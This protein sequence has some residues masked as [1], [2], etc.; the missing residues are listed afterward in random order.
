MYAYKSVFS[1]ILFFQHMND[2]QM[3][4]EYLNS[5]M[6]NGFVTVFVIF[7]LAVGATLPI[8]LFP[9]PAHTMTRRKNYSAT[10]TQQ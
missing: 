3:S 7:M 1:I 4:A 5:A 2:P 10:Q 6:H 8:L 9:G